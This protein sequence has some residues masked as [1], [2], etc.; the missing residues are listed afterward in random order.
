MRVGLIG[1]PMSGKTTFF[2]LLTNSKESGGGFAQGKMGAE[3]GVAK[4]PDKRIDFLSDMYKP[5]KTTLAT[6][7][8]IDIPGM[9]VGGQRQKGA[10]AN[11]FLD[12]VRKVDALVHV[13]RAFRNSSVVHVEGAV[14]PLR[15]IDLVNTE[16]LFA[17]LSIIENRIQRIEAGKKVNK[18]AQKELKVLKKCRDGLESERSIHTQ[19]LDDDERQYLKTFDFLTERPLILLINLDEDQFK[20]GNYEKKEEVLKYARERHIPVIETCAKTELEIIML[21]NEDRKVFMEDL[22]IEETG[23]SR[24]ASAAY[25]YLGM[26]SFFTVGEDEVKAWPIKKGISA[27]AAAGKIHSDIEKGFIRAEVVKYADLKDLG[28]MGKVKEKGLLRLEG[29]DYIVEDGD[30]INFRFNV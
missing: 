29:K 21:E 24:L 10:G 20:S 23:I 3:V 7:E 9:A 15:D 28:S 25:D 26:I 17:D 5:R 13:V 6:I 1:L 22:G 27:K 18:D 4:I 12:F 14:D 11:S 8:V 30:I 2:R 19:E 16:L